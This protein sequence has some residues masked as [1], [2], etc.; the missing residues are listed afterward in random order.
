[1]DV[2]KSALPS[3]VCS[4]DSATFA[5]VNL[6][7]AGKWPANAVKGNFLNLVSRGIYD[8]IWRVSHP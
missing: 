3:V 1:M 8:I 2:P 7:L 5:G 6:S 4:V